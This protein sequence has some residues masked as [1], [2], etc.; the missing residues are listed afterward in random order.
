MQQSISAYFWASNA[1]C[2]QQTQHTNELQYAVAHA[3]WH[4]NSPFDLCV[5]CYCC[6]LFQVPC[7]RLI[8]VGEEMK[9]YKPEFDGLDEEKLKQFVQDYTDGKVKVSTVLVQVIQ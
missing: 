9:R 8:E 5:L 1:V 2:R 7:A 4:N 6:V 3:P